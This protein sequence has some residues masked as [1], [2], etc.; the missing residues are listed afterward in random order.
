MALPALDTKMLDA[1]VARIV[2]ALQPE[3]VILFGSWARGD[4]RPDSDIDLFVQVAPGTNTHDAARKAYAA[5][6][7]MYGDLKRGVDIVVRDRDFVRRYAGLVGTVLTPVMEE[8][9]ILYGG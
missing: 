8:G 2:D 1:L 7:E 9:R 6:R 5:I 3:R 4:A